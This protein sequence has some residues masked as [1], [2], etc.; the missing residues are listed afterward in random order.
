[1]FE[2]KIVTNNVCAECKGGCCQRFRKSVVGLTFHEIKR[3]WEVTGLPINY[4]ARYGKTEPSW[5]KE[6]KGAPDTK[7]VFNEDK[8]IFLRSN[9]YSCIFLTEKGCSLPHETKPITCRFF[10][11]WYEKKKGKYKIYLADEDMKSC[12]LFVKHK[13]RKALE[14]VITEMSET[15]GSLNALIKRYEKELKIFK[16]YKHFLEGNNVEEIM[17]WVEFKG[18]L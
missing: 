3:I 18:E 16:K 5:W 10:P 4:I 15:R 14:P 2:E 17:R 8:S 13:D 6:I 11:L 12:P 7:A 9:N 1:M